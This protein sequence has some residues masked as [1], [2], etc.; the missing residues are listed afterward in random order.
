[1]LKSTKIASIIWIVCCLI[2][3]YFIFGD[4]TGTNSQNPNYLLASIRIATLF[5]GVL[6]F[7]V[8]W[9]STFFKKLPLKTYL[10]LII[11]NIFVVF[12]LFVL[13]YVL[14]IL[15]AIDAPSA[16]YG[17]IPKGDIVCTRQEPYKLAPEFE[18]A[19]SLR[20]QRLEEYGFKMDYSF[21]NCINVEYA[22]L[23]SHDAEGLFYFDTSSP[24]NK[25][26]IYVDQNYRL[27]DDLLT[28]L[29][30]SHEFTHLTQFVDYLKTGKEL[31]CYEKEAEAFFNQIVF[32]YALN[33]EERNSVWARID[34][35][36]RGN[37]ISKSGQNMLSQLKYLND[38]GVTAD[39]YCK[40]LK[41]D[42]LDNYNKC[43][44]DKWRSLILESVKTNPSYIEQCARE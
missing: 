18:R 2:F 34:S 17:E 26:T 21:Y 29:L 16:K 10:L 44:T 5:I 8:M 36:T 41:W 11:F 30:L 32:F 22:D 39:T 23:S 6:A 14:A 1:M 33:A 31:S 7:I 25:L 12:I 38:I 9:L 37:T 27:N 24:L 43:V 40:Q 3:S 42:T 4:S 15:N 35:L 13:P 20:T 19:R 28:A